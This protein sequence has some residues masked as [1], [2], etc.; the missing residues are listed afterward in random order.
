MKSGFF[1][2][3][4][5]TSLPDLFVVSDAGGVLGF[6]A[7]CGDVWCYSPWPPSLR[8]A[9]ITILSCSRSWSRVEFLCNNEA[10]VVILNSGTSCDPSAMH[11][12]HHLTLLA[13]RH[14]FSFPSRHV[15]GRR[16]K[17]ANVIFSFTIWVTHASSFC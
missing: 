3:P 17:A 10:L 9:P 1:H 7:I 15:R 8:M 11:L 4:T 12:M 2:M 14:N 16:N 13:C 5:I 6:G